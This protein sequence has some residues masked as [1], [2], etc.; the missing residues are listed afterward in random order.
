MNAI[1]SLNHKDKNEVVYWLDLDNDSYYVTKS[2]G[3]ESLDS[4]VRSI[5]LA[6]R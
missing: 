3:G 4:M 2:L 1:S 5:A 6:G